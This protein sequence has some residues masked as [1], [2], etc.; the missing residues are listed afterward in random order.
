MSERKLDLICKLVGYR[1][2]EDLSEEE[3]NNFCHLLLA[4]VNF[5]DEQVEVMMNISPRV[6]VKY[7]RPQNDG[8]PWTA[9]SVLAKH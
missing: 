7:C 3:E 5:S 6:L 8:I 9:L 2:A 4:I 1:F